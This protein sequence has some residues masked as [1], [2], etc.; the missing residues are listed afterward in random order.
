VNNVR[1]AGEWFGLG[2]CVSTLVVVRFLAATAT[3]VD[4]ADQAALAIEVR[5][6]DG[7]D[8]ATV[9]GV[10]SASAKQQCESGEGPEQNVELHRKAGL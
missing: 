6:T 4:V 2:V 1:W 8:L 5:F 9:F 7:A 3:V 10:V